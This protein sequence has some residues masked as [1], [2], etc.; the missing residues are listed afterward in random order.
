[1]GVHERQNTVLISLYENNFEL[2]VVETKIV[3]KIFRLITGYGPQ[4]NVPAD[5][6]APFLLPLIQKSQISHCM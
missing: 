3:H 6:K 4:E 5:V 1:M 2:N